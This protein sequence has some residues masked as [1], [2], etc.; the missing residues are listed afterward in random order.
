MIRMVLHPVHGPGLDTALAALPGV[1]LVTPGDGDG[2]AAALGAGAAVLVTYPWED[3]FLTSGL[4][5]VQAISAGVDQ[6]PLET[7]R[8]HEV[9]VTSARGAHSPAVA[10]HA[11]ALLL[12][13]V[14]GLGPA[15]R[16][17]GRRIWAPEIVQESAGMTVAVLG[18]GAIGEEIARRLA[19]LGMRV[20]G[21]KRDP[22]SYAGVAELVVGP[23]RLRWLLERADA[24]IGALPARSD[25]A[26]LI[27]AAALAAL[28]DGWF[29]NVGRGSTVDEEALVAALRHGELRG[30]ALDVT[31]VEPLPSDSPL[32]ELENVI[33]TP[34]MAWA[35]DRLT[36]RL[37]RLIAANLAAYRGHGPWATRI[38]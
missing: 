12:A 20:V 30:A 17:A 27:D 3:R 7:L 6:F 5:W 11:V 1:D 15:M 16:R 13:L 2:V 24:A 33:L 23:D 19:A 10:E 28:G 31:T 8:S 36:P 22:R 9:V 32:W 38:A 29:V 37:T 18:L 14:R 25:T 21:M 34:H 4:R 35:S 26:R